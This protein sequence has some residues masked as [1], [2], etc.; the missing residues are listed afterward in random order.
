MRYQRNR[1][2]RSY[3]RILGEAPR[4][5]GFACRAWK[6]EGFG[7]EPRRARDSERHARG[8]AGLGDVR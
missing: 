4:E 8:R 2:R 5:Y 6:H 7:H 3:G 1:T